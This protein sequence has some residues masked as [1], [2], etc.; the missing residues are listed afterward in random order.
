MPIY[1]CTTTD[2]ADR[3]HKTALAREIAD[4]L[5]DQPRA[6]HLRQRRLPRTAA[7]DIYTDGVPADPVLLTG[8]VRD[9]HPA[10]ETTRLATEIA[11]AVTRIC[12]V[13]QNGF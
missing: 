10:E 11:A 5:S 9:G 8:W 12:D 6:Q 2:D 1:T 7:D 13:D 3:R 4:P